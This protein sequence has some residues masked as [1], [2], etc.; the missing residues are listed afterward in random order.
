MSSHP[1]SKGW[2]KINTRDIPDKIED[3]RPRIANSWFRA[4]ALSER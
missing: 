2:G 3:A 1:A 4:A